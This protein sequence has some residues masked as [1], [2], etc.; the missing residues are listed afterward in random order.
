[1]PILQ[2]PSE[3][4]QT[5]AKSK[6]LSQPS[7]KTVMQPKLLKG[8]SFGSS[9]SRASGSIRAP[10]QK[11]AVSAAECST[12]VPTSES[13][14]S[15][16]DTVTDSQTDVVV[17]DATDTLICIRCNEPTDWASS[18]A[19]SRDPFKRS[20]STCNASYRA[21]NAAIQKEKKASNNNTSKLE[22]YFNGL[23]AEE[24][25]G[26]YRTQKM[27]HD[28][29]A[30]R[31]EMVAPDVTV[32]V[33]DDQKIRKG[34]RRVNCLKTFATFAE[35]GKILNKSSQEIIDEW[36]ALVKDPNVKREQINVG[37]QMELALELFDRIE[38]Y[39][40]EAEE[41]TWR[42]KRV[43]KI[44]E[45]TEI[46]DAI[47]EQQAEF[48]AARR[49][50]QMHIDYAP[51]NQPMDW[52]D[53]T[54]DHNVEAHEQPTSREP[55]DNVMGPSM[56]R[57]STD[58][59]MRNLQACEQTAEEH[60][61]EMRLAAAEAGAQRAKEKEAAASKKALVTGKALIAAKA[62]A[63]QMRLGVTAKIDAL[64]VEHDTTACCISESTMTNKDKDIK[65]MADAIERAKTYAA[66]VIAEYDEKA[67]DFDTPGL[68][69][70]QLKDIKAELRLIVSKFVAESSVFKTNKFRIDTASKAIQAYL[71]KVNR[72][73]MKASKATAAVE[74]GKDWSE[75]PNASAVLRARVTDNKVFDIEDTN[76]ELPPDISKQACA[77]KVPGLMKW[78]DKMKTGQYVKTQRTFLQK[79]L[80]TNKTHTSQDTL[81]TVKLIHNELDDIVHN[82]IH[83]KF[84]D[85]SRP[86]EMD[87][88]KKLK[89]SVWAKGFIR[90]ISLSVGHTQTGIA[91]FGLGEIIFGLEG[92]SNRVMRELSQEAIL[93]L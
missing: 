68:E 7:A 26:W 21:K 2:L 85:L 29:N 80:Q 14:A 81:I 16:E 27:N 50:G 35:R 34:R 76:L 73:S 60:A 87:T 82:A 17:L 58:S 57:S 4:P 90:S 44:D 45:S 30:R 6:P 1:M 46:P 88:D 74:S 91:A 59:M 69:D 54:F 65:E 5:L 10:A 93:E 15:L 83:D 13:C 9:S 51:A 89:D 75:N 61:D 63:T 8:A 24:K 25:V 84:C 92:Q 77:V 32:E 49:G 18:A 12:M 39:T 64:Q 33:D 86:A 20:C 48:E 79:W 62:V 19:Y 47:A 11:S 40:D 55:V 71:R 56:A 42:Q 36:K 23:T 66:A 43:K 53:R 72:D 22:T 28:K 78:A 52:D 38:L 67:K 70:K 31:A 41:Q 37:G 3:Q